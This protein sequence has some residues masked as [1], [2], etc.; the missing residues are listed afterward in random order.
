MVRIRPARVAP[1]DEVDA[2]FDA[3]GSG[4]LAFEAEGGVATAGDAAGDGANDA[5]GWSD[6]AK[7]GAAGDAGGAA[8]DVPFDARAGA[9]AIAGNGAGN[10]AAPFGVPAVGDAVVASELSV[11]L[12]NATRSVAIVGTIATA[13]RPSAASDPTSKVTFDP[14]DAPGTGLAQS[15]FGASLHAPSCT[16]LNDSAPGARAHACTDNAAGGVPAIASVSLPAVW[17]AGTS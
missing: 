3:A 5:D 13:T 10:S 17:W 12:A 15:N 1:S 8:V 9:G 7:S 11:G 2:A 6:E 16:G 4:A 14:S